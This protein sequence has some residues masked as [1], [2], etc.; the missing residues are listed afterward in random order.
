MGDV[1]FVHYRGPEAARA[2]SEEY[3]DAYT[4]IYA[5]PPYD[6]GPLYSRARFLERTGR[7]VYRPGFELLAAVDARTQALAGFCFGFCFPEGG[8][9]GGE[10]SE[11]PADVITVEKVAVIELVLREAY[12]GCGHG[13]ALLETFLAGRSEPWATLLAHPAAPAHARYERWGWRKA[14]TVQPAP[15]APVVDAMVR[16]RVPA[17]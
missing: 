5:E 13:K 7:Q 8:W 1:E 16:N 4:E 10:T 12:R 2:L 15:D 9:W 3:A 11:P 17:R 6:S 14:G